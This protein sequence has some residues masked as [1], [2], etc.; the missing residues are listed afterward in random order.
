MGF[1]EYRAGNID[2]SFCIDNFMIYNDSK[3]PTDAD[4]NAVSG[5]PI[6]GINDVEKWGYGVK[7]SEN[8]TKTIP[9]KGGAVSNSYLDEAVIMKVG[10]NYM[11]SDNKKRKAIFK[12]FET[13]E[14]YGA[15]RKIDGIVY[16][17]FEA[18]LT[19]TGYPVYVHDDG[20]SYDISTAG[21]SS[22]LTIGRD[23]AIVNGKK[24]DLTAAPAV[25]AD[26]TMSPTP[27]PQLQW[28]ISKNSSRAITLP[29]MKWALSSSVRARTFLTEN[30]T[31]A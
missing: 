30:R 11:L 21:G 2:S 26:P 20:I 17:P 13:G 22:M 15:P 7:V 23:T 29:T 5:T 27:I 18:L 14:A 3:T 8:A 9:I 25:I 28:T 1:P 10:S 12:S 31:L 6:D 4:G 19:A 24:V 16:V